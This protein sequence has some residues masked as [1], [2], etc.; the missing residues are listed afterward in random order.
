MAEIE[1]ANTFTFDDG[2]LFAFGLCAYRA[3]MVGVPCR[4]PVVDGDSDVPNR[5]SR[6]C[7]AH[8]TEEE[9]ASE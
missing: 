6:F 3:D 8:Q 7:A 9:K 4:W 2:M 1:A 5:E